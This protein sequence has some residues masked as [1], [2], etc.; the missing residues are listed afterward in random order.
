MLPFPSSYQTE[1][2]IDNDIISQHNTQAENNQASAT[3]SSSSSSSSSAFSTSSPSTSASS[4]ELWRAKKS[5]RSVSHSSSYH[6]LS[7]SSNHRRKWA[8]NFLIFSLFFAAIVLRA[9]I[10]N[11]FDGSFSLTGVSLSSS[12]PS[13]SSLSQSSLSTAFSF[14]PSGAI[15]P[16]SLSQRLLRTHHTILPSA[17]EQQQQLQMEQQ[18]QQLAERVRTSSNL[19]INTDTEKATQ[20]QQHKSTPTDHA[21]SS[22]QL[23]HTNTH[24]NTHTTSSSSSTSSPSSSSSS[25]SQVDTIHESVNTNDPPITIMMHGQEYE[26]LT[27]VQQREKEIR[28]AKASEVR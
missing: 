15:K 24:D 28:E 19:E 5:P 16:L 6:E 2:S 9:Y 3:S 13:S 20:Q 1:D 26:L 17:T 10:H 27:Q 25:P 18:Q 21:T 7:S 22:T 14:S 8:R 12:S 11:A 23:H 4:Y